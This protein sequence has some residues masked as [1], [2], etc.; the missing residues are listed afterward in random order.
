MRIETGPQQPVPAAY[1]WLTP[2]EASELRGALDD[3]L[4]D[5]RDDWHAHISSADYATELTLAVER[6]MCRSPLLPRNLSRMGRGGGKRPGAPRDLWSLLDDTPLTV[7]VGSVLLLLVGFALAA[8]VGS[9]WFL[10]LGVPAALQA[11]AG[12]VGTARS[13]K[14]ALRRRFRRSG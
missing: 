7:F 3:L 13:N 2:S 14:A 4:S 11:V 6:G 12:D 1:L 8:L 9:A 5:P 10:L